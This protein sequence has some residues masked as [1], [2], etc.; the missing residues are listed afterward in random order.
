[1]QQLTRTSSIL[2]GCQQLSQN[3]WDLFTLDGF[4][5]RARGVHNISSR[6]ISGAI[7]IPHEL[8]IPVDDFFWV[9]RGRILLR[10]GRV[11]KI[12]EPNLEWVKGIPLESFTVDEG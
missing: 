10:T 7:I 8:T 4:V 2:V 3:P 1:M 5:M 11:L 9:L 12:F 6:Q